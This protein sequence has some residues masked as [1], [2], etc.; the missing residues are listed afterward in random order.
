MYEYGYEISANRWNRNVIWTYSLLDSL[1]WRH[2]GHDSVSNHQ[3]LYC[4]LNRFFGRR[5]KKT[6]KLRVT[7]LCEGNSAGT[8]E[9]PAEMDSYVENVSI[10]WRHHVEFVIST[11][12]G[13]VSDEKCQLGTPSVYI[14]DIFWKQGI[15]LRCYF[16][17]FA[18]FP[19]TFMFRAGWSVVSTP[20]LQVMSCI[21]WAG[22]EPRHQHTS[23]SGQHRECISWE[24]FPHSWPSMRGSQLPPRAWGFLAQRASN[25]T[26]WFFLYCML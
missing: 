14:C 17:T 21:T 26:F 24:P 11:G 16:Q 7:G 10:W 3:R 13:A 5:S 20:D 8:G 25:G 2:N 4:L 6:S 1:Q 12:F 23:R 19:L 18:I 22:L 15:L 9:F